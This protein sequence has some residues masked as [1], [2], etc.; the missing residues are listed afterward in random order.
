[1]QIQKNNRCVNDAM[2]VSSDNFVEEAS[3][4]EAADEEVNA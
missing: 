3:G 1:M 4:E 2:D